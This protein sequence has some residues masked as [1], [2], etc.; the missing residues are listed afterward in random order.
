[1]R[2]SCSNE[3]KNTSDHGA[4]RSHVG[5]QPLYN[6]PKPSADTVFFKQSQEPEYSKPSPVGPVGC[7]SGCAAS[8]HAHMSRDR[9]T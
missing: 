5:S 9:K 3:M 7:E 2:L 4:M 1:M 6:A 8:R